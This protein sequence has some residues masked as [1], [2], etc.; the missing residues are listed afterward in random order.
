[1]RILKCY[2]EK[3]LK[4]NC[5]QHT[6]LQKIMAEHW[7]CDLLVERL[8]SMGK[9]LKQIPRTVKTNID[10]K[11]SMELIFLM[12][13]IIILTV[14]QDPALTQKNQNVLIVNQLTTEYQTPT[15][16][17]NISKMIYTKT[18]LTNNE[19]DVHNKSKMK[20][21]VR[22]WRARLCSTLSTGKIARM[23]T[24]PTD[25]MKCHWEY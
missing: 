18:H 19:R 13:Q 12:Y 15:V 7:I 8:I 17:K 5:L 22:K 25:S 21:D 23:L 1:M 16:H 11:Y 2:N 20:Q 10:D 24:S 6:N 9:A 3:I 4:I 14:L